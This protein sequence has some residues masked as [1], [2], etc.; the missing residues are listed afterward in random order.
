M[1]VSRTQ[2]VKGLLHSPG[3]RLS[4]MLFC[5]GVD[6]DHLSSSLGSVYTIHST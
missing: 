2:T 4:L 5:M 6:K 3:P 1:Q